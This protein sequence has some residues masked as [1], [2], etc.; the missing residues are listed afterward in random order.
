MK[1]R[2]L[3]LSVWLGIANYCLACTTFLIENNGRFAFGRNYDWV[4]GTGMVYTN[5][6]RVSKHALLT[7]EGKSFNWIS[8]FASITFNQYGK[9][10]PNGG[11]NEKGLVVEVMWL[12]ESQYPKPDER[13]GLTVL[14]WVQYQLDHAENVDEVITSD[15]N[16]RIVAAGA[17]L[18]FLVADARGNAATIEFLNGKMVVHRSKQSSFPVLTNSTYETSL[19]AFNQGATTNDNSL[20]R[21]ATAC[22][23][24]QQYKQQESKLNVIDYS[25]SILKN[26][27]QGSFT[28]WSIVYDISN[29]KIYFNT[30]GYEQVKEINASGL[31]LNCNDQR[32]ALNINLKQGGNVNKTFSNYSSSNNTDMLMQ[33]FRESSNRIDVNKNLQLALSKIPSTFTCSK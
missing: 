23:M 28:K 4:T 2:T 20:E 15:N 5:A 22:K 13:P 25:F 12:N 18:H 6:R 11:M 31:F 14:Q 1:R 16:I 10:F 29:R 24:L 7:D 27:S 21:F 17:P 9:E 32:L 30:N 26:V 3:L 8:A 19:T 33:A